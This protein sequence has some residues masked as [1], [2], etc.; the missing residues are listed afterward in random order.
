MVSA[1]AVVASELLEK[2]SL[3]EL[4]FGSIT[5]IVRTTET[6]VSAPTVAMV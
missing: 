3:E 1:I 5:E 6:F 4:A 2:A